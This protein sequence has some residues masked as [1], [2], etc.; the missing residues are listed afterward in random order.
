MPADAPRGTVS[1][2]DLRREPD[3]RWFFGSTYLGRDGERRALMVDGVGDRVGVVAARLAEALGTVCDAADGFGY[4]AAVQ[5]GR[6]VLRRF[7]RWKE[8]RT[9][10]VTNQPRSVWNMRTQDEVEEGADGR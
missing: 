8:G 5:V 3:G 2:G 7:E 4:P 10:V 1:C 9:G 6:D